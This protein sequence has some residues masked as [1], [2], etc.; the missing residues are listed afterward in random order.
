M[1][2]HSLMYWNTIPGLR[3]NITSGTTY[4]GPATLEGALDVINT[5]KLYYPASL[6]CSSYNILVPS[7]IYCTDP[8]LS[9]QSISGNSY[10]LNLFPNP[11]NSGD[12]MIPY[13]LKT[14]ANIQFKILDYTGRV[15][16]NL[17][18]EHKTVGT[19]NEQVNID[20]LANGVYLFKACINE[21]CQT[22]K[23]VKL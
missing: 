23:F 2:S 15:V 1:T 3:V 13:Q 10:N 11:I 18:N 9:V 19:Y 4:P 16:M 20:A 21:K 8:N 6:G 14:E 12:I 22:I 17:D 5:S 7:T